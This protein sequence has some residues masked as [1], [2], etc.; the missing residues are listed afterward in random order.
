MAEKDKR[1]RKGRSEEEDQEK[2]EEYFRQVDMPEDEEHPSPEEEPTGFLM[3]DQ[4]TEDEGRPLKDEELED[5]LVVDTNEEAIMDEIDEYTTDEEVEEDFEERQQLTSGSEELADKLR[6]HHSK[7]PDLSG[8]D[9]DAAW[10][11]MDVSGEEGVG[12]TTPTPDQD[13]VD[14]LGEAVGLS[15]DSDEPLNTEEKFLERDRNRWELDPASAEDSELEPESE[16][17][18][19][20][21]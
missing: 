3:V 12:G 10:E 17:E 13:V 5:F 6:Q 9:V 19:E 2:E 15:Y 16:E 8:G 7:K 11:D 4:D 20:E 1:T 18:E 14:E 21:E